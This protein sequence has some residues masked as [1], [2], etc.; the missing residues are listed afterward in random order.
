MS[1]DWN[2]HCVDCK[3]THH[4]SDANHQDELML[5]LCR[6]A[7]AIAALLEL[8]K[9]ARFDIQLRTLWGDVDI[10]WFREHLGHQLLPIDEYGR[11][12]QHCR[13]RIYC[14]ECKITAHQCALLEGHEG[15]HERSKR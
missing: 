3:S 8:Q 12:Y 6:H 1:T 13:E 11:L 5:A 2:V 15:P 14:G 9:E 10:A 7:E 4:F